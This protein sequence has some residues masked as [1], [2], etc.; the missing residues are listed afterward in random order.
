M[1][2]YDMTCQNAPIDIQTD[3]A[4][5]C[6]LK[7][8]LNYKYGDSSCSMTNW[9]LVLLIGYDGVSDV[10]FNN[11]KYKPER[12]YIFKPSIHTYSGQ[13]AEAE[14][15]MFHSS[16]QGGLIISIPIVIGAKM[17]Q[18]SYLMKDLISAAPKQGERSSPSI[19][20][21]NA[22][23]LIP[24]SRYY[25]YEA[26]FINSP[27]NSLLYQYVVFHPKYGALSISKETF[28]ILDALV[29]PMY[30]VTASKGICAV[31][32][33]GTTNNGFNGDGQIYIDCQPT[34]QS[35]EEIVY[36]ETGAVSKM[37]NDTLMSILMIVIGVVIIFGT[38]M[39][40]KFV[41]GHVSVIT[42]K[43][44]LVPIKK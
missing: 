7:C 22:N 42:N 4:E 40:M 23:Y 20:D 5:K 43:S 33:I 9:N 1:V 27:C 13:P 12:I 6:S 31:N 3:G 25:T 35:E 44:N 24:K 15:F 39:A 32:M 30:G 34:G 37:P 17:T 29:Q 10:V 36:K 2:S 11:V 41:L 18:G 28:K 19:A 8:R 38:F 26:P 16:N 14:I 21:Y